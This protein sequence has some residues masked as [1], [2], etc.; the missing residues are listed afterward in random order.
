[1]S[2]F[3]SLSKS[4]QVFRS[5]HCCIDLEKAGQRPSTADSERASKQTLAVKNGHSERLRVPLSS[6]F[7]KH[8]LD[9]LKHAPFFQH[10][11]VLSQICSRT[12]CRSTV[13]SPLTRCRFASTPPNSSLQNFS[14]N[15]AMCHLHKYFIITTS[16][17][18]NRTYF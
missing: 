14:C 2:T 16:H 7:L 8:T 5:L 4:L 18:V 12:A 17:T 9:R 11:P 1:V 3:S 15:N 13:G 6:N 10:Q